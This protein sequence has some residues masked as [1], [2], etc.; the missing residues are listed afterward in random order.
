MDYQ[1]VLKGIKKARENSK[2]RGFK[3][4]FDCIINLK[5][6][7]LKKPEHKLDFGVQIEN[8]IK[9]R[10]LKIAAVV[11]HNIKDA[12]KVFDKVLY[13]DD[14]EQYRGDLEKIK[15]LSKEVDKFVVQSTLMVNFAQI[16]GR[17]L[18]PLNKMPNPRLGMVI[19][20]KTNIKELYEKLQKTVHIQVKKSLVVQFSFGGEDVDDETLAKSLHHVL[21][22]LEHRLPLGSN[23]IKDIFVKTTMG[24]LVRL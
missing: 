12:E 6:L 16:F 21:D 22:V 14:L 23:N 1:T 10:P 18:G 5:N 3:Q 15:K 2:K 4:T 7:D 20:D 8:N 19:T 11:E 17:Y 13:K 9:H 24:G